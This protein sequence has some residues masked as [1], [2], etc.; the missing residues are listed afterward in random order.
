MIDYFVI[1]VMAAIWAFMPFDGI[2]LVTQVFYEKVVQVSKHFKIGIKLCSLFSFNYLKLYAET[3][4]NNLI[5]C[6]S[7][8][9][10][11]Y[12]PLLFV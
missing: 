3:W 10:V 7:H 1:I 11:T 6:L 2:A 8:D 9:Y 5:V 4:E 12:Y